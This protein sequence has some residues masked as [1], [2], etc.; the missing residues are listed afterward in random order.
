[1]MMMN[2]LIICPVGV[3]TSRMA[4]YIVSWTFLLVIFCTTR[5]FH[6]LNSP[7]SRVPPC[8]PSPWRR[9]CTG[10][11]FLQRLR[12][13]CS[14]SGSPDSGGSKPRT[15]RSYWC[16]LRQ[17]CQ[18]RNSPQT[19]W[20]TRN[21]DV[22]CG[23][24]LT[25]LLLYQVLYQ[26]YTKALPSACTRSLPRWKA[27]AIKNL[28][29]VPVDLWVTRLSAQHWHNQGAGTW[30]TTFILFFMGDKTAVH[31]INILSIIYIIINFERL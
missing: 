28:L 5:F 6:H 29:K 1:M 2:A 16:P 19:M 25:S 12:T 4:P 15:R 30:T 21:V 14:I 31:R 18:L 24:G 26:G 11:L 8:F 7:S 23:I 20:M 22:S 3:F 13:S 10:V 9:L 27:Q 17:W